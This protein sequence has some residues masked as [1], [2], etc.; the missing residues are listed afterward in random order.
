M[1]ASLVY[2][3][4]GPSSLRSPS[5]LVY[6]MT[7]LGPNSSGQWPA[8]QSGIYVSR[9]RTGYGWKAADVASEIIKT[10]QRSFEEIDEHQLRRMVKENLR[11][12]YVK[13]APGQCEWEPGQSR[14]LFFSETS[15]RMPTAD[16]EHGNRDRAAQGAV[17][18]LRTHLREY[19]A[20]ST[21]RPRRSPSARAEISKK[22]KLRSRARSRTMRST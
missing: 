2:G 1:V 4:I 22:K 17:S 12:C 20:E 7:G 5:S 6:S 8:F 21:S 16:A 11:V 3:S 19:P 13:R 10:I 15:R 14:D 9:A 18:A